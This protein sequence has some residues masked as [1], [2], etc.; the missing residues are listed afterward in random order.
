MANESDVRR[1]LFEEIGGS[2]FVAKDY[3]LIKL[4]KIQNKI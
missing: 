1:H 3:K 4:V 2:N